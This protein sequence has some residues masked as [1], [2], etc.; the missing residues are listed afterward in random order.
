M[1]KVDG[2]LKDANVPIENISLL[3]RR[4][5]NL[6]NTLLT[7]T[8]AEQKSGSRSMSKDVATSRLTPIDT[9]E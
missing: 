5:H 8:L 4:I 2:V 3:T 9:G 1:R 6:S 7:T